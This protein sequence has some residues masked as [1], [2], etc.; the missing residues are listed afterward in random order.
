MEFLNKRL[1]FDVTVYYG[2][3]KNQILPLS[4]SGTTGYTSQIINAGLI[5]NQ[6]IE[7]TL[8]ATP[9]KSRDFE[10]NIIGTMSS[11]QN[12]VVELME[13]VDY[14]RLAAAPFKV[15][16]GAYV[17]EKYGMIMGTDYKYDD[18][19]NKLVN[20]SGLY[21]YTAG[22]V[23]LGSVY[24]D[25]LAGVT[26]SFRY[27]NIELSVLFDGQSGGK[28]FSTSYMWGMYSGMLDE[29]A[30][31][32]EL[33]KPNRDLEDPEGGYLVVGKNDDGTDNATRVDAETYGTYHYS[34]PA[35]QNVFRSD[36]IKLREL[37]LSYNIPLKS[38]AA[39]EKLTISAYG[40]NLA[41]WG[42]DT[43]HFDPEMATTSSGNIQGIEGGALPSI[44][45]FGVNVG[46]QF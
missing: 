7:V 26:N 4:L 44:A 9:V 23:P 40:R 33:G 27:K 37:T 39:I 15:E 42:P 36:Y 21:Q 16:V 31:L 34:G 2:E 17:G 1:G 14:Y 25:L 5:S 29:T 10:W 22:N 32:N 12:K 13:G 6:G 8:K 30:G 19:G 41:I 3:T 28:F 24:P 11:N 43:K 18:N 46:I 45:T 38:S 20:A 35:A